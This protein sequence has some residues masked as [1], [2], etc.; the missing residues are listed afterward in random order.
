MEDNLKEQG[1]SPEIVLV[2]EASNT[3]FATLDLYG[4]VAVMDWDAAQAG[5]FSDWKYLPTSLDES[6]GTAFPDRASLVQVGTHPCVLVLNAGPAGGATLVDLAG[7]KVAARWRVPPG[8]EKPVV[9]PGQSKAYSV[10]SGKTKAR[11]D[12]QEELDKDYTPGRSVYAFD[13]GPDH[14]ST[15]TRLQESPLQYY[16]IRLAG[17]LGPRGPLL[18]L[19]AGADPEQA[20]TILLYDPSRK[21]VLDR[22]PAAGPIGQFE[23]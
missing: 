10:C 20:D 3:L 2:C 12:E 17:V 22:L 15:A 11:S 18:L 7:R 9:F 16:L 5:R 21:E 6:W 13:F 1:P 8:L 19:A 23:G 4:A 14:Q